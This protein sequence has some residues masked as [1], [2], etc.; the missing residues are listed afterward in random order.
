MITFEQQRLPTS[1]KDKDWRK[2]QVDSIISNTNEFGGDWY[3]M[4][5]NYRMKNNQVDQ[6]E[7]R[8][9]CDTL[10]LNYDYRSS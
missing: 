8:E 5:Q 2:N 4:W 9:Y 1:K 7:Y 3:R 6:R 10:G